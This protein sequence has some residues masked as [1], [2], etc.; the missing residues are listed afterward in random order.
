MHSQLSRIFYFCSLLISLLIIFLL[1]S[2]DLLPFTHSHFNF[3]KIA[4]TLTSKVFD[5]MWNAIIFFC[6]WCFLKWEI[7]TQFFSCQPASRVWILLILCAHG[8]YR[9]RRRRRSFFSLYCRFN[10]RSLNVFL[11]QH[12]LYFFLNCKTTFLF[13]YFSQQK[14]FSVQ[15]RIFLK[16]FFC[17]PFFP[18]N[19]FKF[20]SH[21]SPTK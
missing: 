4:T 16:Q 21:K 2:V 6:V 3:S 12:D 8:N 20:L 10:R 5:F 15:F 9:T 13:F 18:R 17:Y 11:L 19:K 1:T 7:L 14:Y